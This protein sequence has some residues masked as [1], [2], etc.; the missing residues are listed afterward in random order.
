MIVIPK[1]QLE[2]IE[3]S[4]SK[5]LVCE[6]CNIIEDIQKTQLNK[7]D[8]LGLIKKTFKNKVYESSS[9]RKKLLNAFTDGFTYS[10]VNLK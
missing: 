3:S 1:K 10:E 6:M 7:N 2:K 4:S 9:Y 8:A 5:V